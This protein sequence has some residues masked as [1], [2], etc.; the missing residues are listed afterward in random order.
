M[1]TFEMLTVNVKC[2]ISA[3]LKTKETNYIVKTKHM[4]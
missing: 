3:V 4:K 1:Q 2:G